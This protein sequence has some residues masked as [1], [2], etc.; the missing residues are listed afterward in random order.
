MA[1]PEQP[2]QKELKS[3]LN[4]R[5]I[6]VYKDYESNKIR[7]LGNSTFLCMSYVNKKA[8]LARK[9]KVVTLPGVTT[10]DILTD[11]TLANIFDAK[12]KMTQFGFKNWADITLH[13]VFS[14]KTTLDKSLQIFKNNP[15]YISASQAVNR[16]TSRFG[17][18]VG[19]NQQEV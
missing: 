7:I 12:G 6:D 16:N 9:S 4:Q 8:F 14:L 10:D 15:V 18:M 17:A 3:S 11:F 2:H 5:G 13:K 1:N 19:P